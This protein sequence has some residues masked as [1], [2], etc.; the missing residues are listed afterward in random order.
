MRKQGFAVVSNNSAHRS[1]EDVPV[2]IP[3]I[4]P[5]H[6]DIIPLQQKK[7]GWTKGFLVVKPNCSIQSYM[8]PLYALMK[9]GYKI[10]KMIV[11]TLQA[12]VRGRLSG[13]RFDR[14]D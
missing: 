2:M 10:D 11:T 12:V 7:H 5:E 6:L 8:I 9:A 3:E 4:N 1:T 13:T 14:P